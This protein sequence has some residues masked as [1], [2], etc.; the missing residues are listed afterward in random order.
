MKDRGKTINEV[1]K[2]L[3]SIRMVTIT[4]EISGKEKLMGRVFINGELER[5]TMENGV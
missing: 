2:G 4:L 5:Y 1:E 3:K